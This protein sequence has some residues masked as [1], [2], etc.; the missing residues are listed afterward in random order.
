MQ[1]NSKLSL[2]PSIEKMQEKVRICSYCAEKGTTEHTDELK[3][4]K[5]YVDE[6]ALSRG[7]R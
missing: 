1:Q 5:R 4:L 2:T 3:L 6:C 7:T